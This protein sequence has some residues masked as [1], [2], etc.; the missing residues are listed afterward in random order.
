M[1]PEFALC[2]G[3]LAAD[4]ADARVFHGQ[5]RGQGRMKGS[6]EGFFKDRGDH[7]TSGDLWNLRLCL[8]MC[9][10]SKEVGARIWQVWRIMGS[11]VY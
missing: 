4:H 3:T 7:V 2:F 11:W 5:H 8:G 1:A 9:L 10:G 6:R